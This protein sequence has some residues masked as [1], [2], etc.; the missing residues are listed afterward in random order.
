MSPNF[1]LPLC[2]HFARIR[3]IVP[4]SFVDI[5]VWWTIVTFKIV[6]L[7]SSLPGFKG[8]RQISSCYSNGSAFIYDLYMTWPFSLAAFNAF[9]LVCDFSVL[10]II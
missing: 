9:S 10:S 8:F 1:P 3:A 4:F 2:D 5:V 7:F 6:Y